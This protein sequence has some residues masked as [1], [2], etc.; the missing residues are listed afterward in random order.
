M[1]THLNLICHLDCLVQWQ[2]FCTAT[3]VDVLQH[4]EGKRQRMERKGVGG[5]L[6]IFIWPYSPARLLHQLTYLHAAVSPP[7]QPG[8]KGRCATVLS[9]QHS[10]CDL[11]TVLSMSTSSANTLA[12]LALSC[13][14]R[15]FMKSLV[16]L[17]NRSHRRSLFRL[18]PRC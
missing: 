12:H 16:L 11:S 18:R 10:D 4:E 5:G 7:W 17:Q 3:T 6:W 15:C 9:R 1:A 14:F 8:L 2:R 13:I